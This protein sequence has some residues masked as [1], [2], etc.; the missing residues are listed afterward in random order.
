MGLEDI[1]TKR[2]M[3]VRNN[4]GGGE[5]IFILENIETRGKEGSNPKV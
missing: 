4:T 1:V 3:Y 5:W 2:V